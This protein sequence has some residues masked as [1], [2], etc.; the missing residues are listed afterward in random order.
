MLELWAYAIGIMYSPGPVNLLGLHGGVQRSTRQNLGYFAGVASAMFLLFLTMSLVGG[1]LITASM[2]PYVSIVGCTYIL[3]IAF[4]LLR[5][6]VSFNADQK[7]ASHLT[8]MD[9]LMLQLLNPKGYIAT[10]PIVTIQFPAAGISG[11]SSLFW[12]AFYQYSLSVHP[13]LTHWSAHCL[14][15]R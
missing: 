10:L 11:Y 6:D 9:G 13:R 14:A 12:I 15:N 7:V 1:S 2:L 5:A 8:Y 3:Y 4:K